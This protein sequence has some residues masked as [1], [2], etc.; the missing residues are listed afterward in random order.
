MKMKLLILSNQAKASTVGAVLG[1][2]GINASEFCKE[3]NQ[4]TTNRLG[5]KDGVLI[6]VKINL[7]DNGVYKFKVGHPTMSSLI[8]RIGRYL[9]PQSIYE[10]AK[11]LSAF[12]NDKLVLEKKCRQIIASARSQGMIL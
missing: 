9:S 3:L 12:N 1:Q 6:P 2:R 7:D 4:E 5:F 11:M 10:L 8:L